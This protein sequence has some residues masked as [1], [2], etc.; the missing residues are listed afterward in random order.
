M[1]GATG[2]FQLPP[3]VATSVADALEERILDGQLAPGA[4]LLQLDLA[5]AFGVSR[6]PVRD[7]L[8]ILEQRRLAVRVPRKG[9]IV[10]PITAQGVRDL[11]AAR[12]LLE[13]EITRLA[14]P[15]LTTADVA[16][17]EATVARQRTAAA[18]R[19]LATMRAADREFHATIWR[20]CGNAVLEELVVDIWRRA[21]QARSYGHR[22]PDWGERSIARHG[23]I[24]AAIRRADVEGA[25][26]AAVGAVEAA[27]AE[28]LTQLDGAARSEEAAAP[29]AVG[30]EGR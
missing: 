4:A 22:L 29:A 14:V 21:L 23:R 6:V 16:A 7:A 8:A 30:A 18:T 9:V 1:Q 17:L 27:E 28:I 2:A 26:A 19:D 15:R 5:A 24:L 12:R 11:F 3:N 13:V 20:A 25:T 10:Q